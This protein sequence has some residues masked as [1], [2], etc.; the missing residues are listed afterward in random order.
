MTYMELA[1]SF[2]EHVNRFDL[3]VRIDEDAQRI[4]DAILHQTQLP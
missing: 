1:E 4:T 2:E 3:P